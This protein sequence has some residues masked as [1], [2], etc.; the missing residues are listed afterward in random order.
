MV[1]RQGIAG[2]NRPRYPGWFFCF[3]LLW[4]DMSTRASLRVHSD[5]YTRPEMVLLHKMQSIEQQGIQPRTSQ[6][7][8]Q[9]EPSTV[10]KFSQK[11]SKLDSWPRSLTC[12]SCPTHGPCSWKSAPSSCPSNR[13]CMS[14]PPALSGGQL[15]LPGPSPLGSS[16]CSS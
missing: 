11:L 15:P 4:S 14:Q 9:R 1:E 7:T 16:L 12:T 8:L 10:A 6:Q 3:S 13:P 5:L 2:Q